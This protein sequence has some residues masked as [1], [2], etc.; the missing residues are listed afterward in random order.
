MGELWVQYST[1]SILYV[2]PVSFLTRRT[3]RGAD[4]SLNYPVHRSLE[5]RYR[6]GSRYQPTLEEEVVDVDETTG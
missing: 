2:L 1:R 4:V 3:N 6:N 5:L